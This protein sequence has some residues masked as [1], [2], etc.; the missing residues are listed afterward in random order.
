MSNRLDDGAQMRI[1]DQ[2]LRFA[3]G[4]NVKGKLIDGLILGGT[5]DG[6]PLSE[7]YEITTSFRI[8]REVAWFSSRFID[9]VNAGLAAE[10]AP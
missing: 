2:I 7:V 1:R 10:G 6:M 4:F 3:H 5:S 8:E 9:W